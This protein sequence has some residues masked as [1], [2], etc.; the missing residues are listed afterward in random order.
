MKIIRLQIP[1]N[2]LEYIGFGELFQDL[3][4]VEILKAFQYDQTHIFSLQRIKFKSILGS[5]FETLIKQK[6][7]PQSFQLLSRLKDEIT[8][9]MY[10]NKTTGFFPV[11]DSGPWALVFPIFT[12]KEFL[13]IN[14]IAQNEYIPK[15]LQIIS[16]FT[17][18]YK[19]I[20]MTNVNKANKI[21]D[22]IGKYAIHF[23]D[24]TK[25]QKEVA[26]FA[27]KNGYFRSP[28]RITANKIA[29]NFGISITAVNRHLKT[30]HHSK[31]KKS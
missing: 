4:W 21:D 18:S 25:R 22:I 1:G 30:T 16:S 12:S 2:F 28:K 10:Q 5:D 29:E 7:N 3:E 17:E 8:C 23:P 20:A 9:I 15:L 24:F 31:G 6:F 11:I 13:L 14:I 26:S 19:I 27:A